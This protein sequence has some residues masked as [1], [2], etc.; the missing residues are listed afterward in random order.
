MSA[1]TSSHAFAEC[2]ADDKDIC[3]SVRSIP[4]IVQAARGGNVVALFP[5]QGQAWASLPTATVSYH[6]HAEVLR[7]ASMRSIHPT[8]PTL[9]E[10][11]N[12]CS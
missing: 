5:Y 10:T 8:M 11:W 9:D 3:R 4:T 7:C 6:A 12:R 1:A 2:H